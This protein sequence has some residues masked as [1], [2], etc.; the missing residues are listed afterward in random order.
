MTVKC[1]H[2][3]KQLKNDVGVRTHVSRKH[4]NIGKVN[5]PAT[6]E[7]FDLFSDDRKSDITGK[8]L[9]SLILDT[10]KRTLGE[11]DYS[12]ELE[13]ENKEFKKQIIDLKQ[14]NSDLTQLLAKKDTDIAKI[15]N[16]QNDTVKKYNELLENAKVM[17]DLLED[18][19]ESE[20][21]LKLADLQKLFDSRDELPLDDTMVQLLI[22]F[23]NKI[24]DTFD[25]DKE[26]IPSNIKFEAIYFAMFDQFD[27]LKKILEGV[28]EELE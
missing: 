2:C 20:E 18:Y 21:I 23:T 12:L 28:Q 26:L 14:K 19:E 4:K 27:Q 10:S 6:G 11:A 1:P 15:N 22:A 17:N 7:E 16:Q 13:I 9:E 25:L 3:S 5:L 24:C 8:P